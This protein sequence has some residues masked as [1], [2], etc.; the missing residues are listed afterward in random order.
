MPSLTSHLAVALILALPMSCAAPSAGDE[1][2]GASSAAIK[3]DPGPI[4]PSP[5]SLTCPACACLAC[6]EVQGD[7]LAVTL[8][9]E[10]QTGSQLFAGVYEE[11]AVLTVQAIGP[12]LAVPTS[13]MLSMVSFT[14]PVND[15][16][17]LGEPT[18]RVIYVNVPTELAGMP[19]GTHLDL[20]STQLC[21]TEAC[22]NLL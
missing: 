5:H 10:W 4:D 16:F 8:P 20:F 21:K 17:T 22:V 13:R 19:I 14:T 15:D 7:S 1:S 11:N 3:A 18:P 12:T 9:P 6:G 2:I